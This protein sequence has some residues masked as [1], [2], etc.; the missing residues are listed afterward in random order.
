MAENENNTVNEYNSF[1]YDN[2]SLE[3]LH[4]VRNI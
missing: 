4:K 1:D 2:K 3:I